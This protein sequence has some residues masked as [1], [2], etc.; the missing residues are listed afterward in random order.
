MA[1]PRTARPAILVWAAGLLAAC[2]LLFIWW[3]E[4]TAPEGSLS[5]KPLS[6]AEL[7]GWQTSDPRA[8][9]EAF[10]LSCAQLLRKPASEPMSGNGYAGTVGDG[11][12]ACQ[13]IP[14]VSSADV[15][16]RW[17][18]ENFVPLSVRAGLKRE[19]LF[20]GYYEPELRGSHVRHGTYQTPVYGLPLGLVDVDLGAF[21]P[22]LRG[23]RIAGRI[24]SHRLGP[25][26][27][28]GE[29]D[30][31][32]LSDAAIR[33]FASDPVAV[34][35][36]HIQGS[37]RVRFEDGTVRR[38]A[39]DGQN[40]WPYTPVGRVLIEEGEL[41]RKGMS[42]QA[43]KRWMKDHPAK[44]REA[45]E[46]DQSYV[47]FKDAPLGDPALGSPGALG[48]ALTPGASIA[49][50]SRIHPLGAPFFIVAP[51]PDRD[52]AKPENARASLFIAQDIG[53]G[54][55]GAVQR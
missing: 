19:A 1:A 29:I 11:T 6:F 14:A 48:A 15:A 51:I 53:G 18:E 17:F 7:A 8:A 27:N 43:I 41:D 42:L 21:R 50:D 44:A 22:S 30:R 16:R 26:A 32:G 20:T 54:E 25:F 55:R 5:L 45:M 13:H 10:R 28:R 36:L 31:H 38:V 39:Y 23:E 49:V 47:F 37:G 40:G 52:P 2:A 33:F 24:E 35:F 3:Y 46:K 34:F 4:R 9:L 12:T